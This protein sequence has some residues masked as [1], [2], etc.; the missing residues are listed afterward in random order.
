M[1]LKKLNENNKTFKDLVRLERNDF[2]AL[3]MSV[4]SYNSEE[5]IKVFNYLN[6][7]FFDG[8][9]QLPFILP[10]PGNG[11]MS[12]FYSKIA[13]KSIGINVEDFFSLGYAFYAKLLHEMIHAKFDMQGINDNDHTSKEWVSEC[14]RILELLG[15]NIP[16]NSDD[17]YKLRTFPVG[18]INQYKGVAEHFEKSVKERNKLEKLPGGYQLQRTTTRKNSVIFVVRGDLKDDVSSLNRREKDYILQLAEEIKKE[19]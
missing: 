15:I 5:V 10:V 13:I 6:D 9:V 2:I 14:K 17:T 11:N 8:E 1:R 7:A 4:T 16:L 18:I 12:G 19:K 3:L